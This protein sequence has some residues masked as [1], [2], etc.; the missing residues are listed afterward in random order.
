MTRLHTWLN[1]LPEAQASEALRTCCAAERWVASMLSHRPFACS[2]RVLDTARDVWRSMDKE[3]ILEAFRGHPQIGGDLEVL[4]KKY[5]TSSTAHEWSKHEQ[6]DVQNADTAVL[7]GLRDG[8]AAYF[9]RFGYIFI[10]CASGKTA[11]QILELLKTRLHNTPE[12]E[13]PIAARE[14]EKIL[15]L[16]LRKLTS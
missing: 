12:V 11:L 4:K 9:K 10:V 5:G 2:E 1:G 14:Q 6:A 3:D 15:L 16:R 13:L 7:L 8:N